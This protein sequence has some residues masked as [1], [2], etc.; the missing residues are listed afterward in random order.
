MD[1]QMEAGTGNVRGVF[2]HGSESVGLMVVG[3]IYDAR[4]SLSIY[5]NDHPEF[6]PETKGIYFFLFNV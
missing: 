1:I 3:G 4:F 5:L 2:L 6:N